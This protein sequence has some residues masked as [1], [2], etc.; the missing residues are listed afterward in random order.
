M[1][2]DADLLAIGPF[3]SDIADILDYP[4]EY[5][6]GVKP[7]TKVITTVFL[8]ETTDQSNGLA[9][10]LGI[11]PWD[12]GAHEIPFSKVDAVALT[13]W[14]EETDPF[15]GLADVMRML[16]LAQKGFTFFFRPNG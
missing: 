6:E 12:F 11:D 2:M 15:E 4:P 1:G 13:E 7:G 5:Y 16:R 14:A 10:A 3:S 8:C 9:E